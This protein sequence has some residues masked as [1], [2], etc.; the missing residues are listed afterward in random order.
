[1]DFWNWSLWVL[2]PV[3]LCIAGFIALCVHVGQTDPKLIAQRN[4]YRQEALD[5]GFIPRAWLANLMFCI[6]IACWVI[7]GIA[8]SR[9]AVIQGIFLIIIPILLMVW[10]VMNARR[11]YRERNRG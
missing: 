5:A 8:I 4:R 6:M 9:G 3:A 2:V 11:L 7:A 10:E 1:M